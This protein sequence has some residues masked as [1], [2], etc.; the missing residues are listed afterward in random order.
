MSGVQQF[1]QGKGVMCKIDGGDGEHSVFLVVKRVL[2]M[3]R[4]YEDDVW[5]RMTMKNVM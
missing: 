5:A 3:L 1:V 2:M 4:Q